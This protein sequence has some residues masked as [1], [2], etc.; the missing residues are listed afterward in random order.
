MRPITT[1]SIDTPY[2]MFAEGGGIS[3]STSNHKQSL[4]MSSK[5][6]TRHGVS[7]GG[8]SSLKGI[9]KEG[10][11]G[12]E[13]SSV[14]PPNF[15]PMVALLEGR[16]CSVEMSILK[17]VATVAFCDAT[18]IAEIHQKVFL[19][20][21]GIFLWDRIQLTAEE[22]EKFRSLKVIVKIGPGVENVDLEAAAQKQIAVCNVDGYG[23]EEAADTTIGMILNLFRRINWFD[24]MVKDGNDFKN[25]ENIE[26]E[27]G[28][29]SRIRGHILGLIG[30][31]RVGV[32]VA[33]RAK[34]FGFNVI[35][36]DPYLED[37]YE[38]SYGLTRVHN[39]T[40]LLV[41]SHCVSLHCG[42]RGIDSPIINDYTIHLMR[43]GAFLVNVSHRRLVDE[44]S[45]AKALYR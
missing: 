17:D 39:M 21:W 6:V 32:A 5:R 43:P 9:L 34:A 7:A 31:G 20:S 19:E 41:Q 11:G 1:K 45:V 25:F 36:F 30:L 13:G 3:L 8:E 18:S 26:E 15:R 14:L 10:R 29:C 22:L 35:F 38:N 16:D 12:V 44:V 40:E 37:G 4:K 2:L 27:G 42:L 28:I 23:I 33:L 24:K